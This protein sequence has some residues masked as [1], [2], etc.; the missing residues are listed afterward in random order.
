MDT[1]DR[2]YVYTWKPGFTYIWVGNEFG[3]TV[4]TE[5]PEGKV[6]VV[7]VKKV[8]ETNGNFFGCIVRWNWLKESKNCIG[9]PVDFDERYKET[10]W[11]K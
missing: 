6:F 9:A 1:S 3:R 4:R 10:C 11:S 7:L 5:A 2:V 8:L